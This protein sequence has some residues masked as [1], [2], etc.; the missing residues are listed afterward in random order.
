M[1]DVLRETFK[2]FTVCTKLAE[3]TILYSK[4]LTTAKKKVTSTGARPDTTDYYWL[5]SPVPNHMS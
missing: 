2:F 3:M 4:D 1:S 5:S